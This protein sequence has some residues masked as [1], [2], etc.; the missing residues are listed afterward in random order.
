[1][2]YLS[3]KVHDCSLSRHVALPFFGLLL[4]GVVGMGELTERRTAWYRS[5]LAPMFA[6][7]PCGES[8]DGHAGP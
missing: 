1:M 5:Q 4:P 3:C 8:P 2:N 6:G 7:A